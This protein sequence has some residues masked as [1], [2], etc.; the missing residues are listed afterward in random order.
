MHQL[1]AMHY[2]RIVG[3][4]TKIFGFKGFQFRLQVAGNTA[5]IK[6]YTCQTQE[7]MIGVIRALQVR[8]SYFVN[9]NPVFVQ[10]FKF[11]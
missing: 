4:G 8:I 9:I 5:Q 10:Y 1:F 3:V 7:T 11:Q 6:N 2:N